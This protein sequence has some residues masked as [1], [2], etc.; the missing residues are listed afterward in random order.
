MQERLEITLAI[1][2]GA[3]GLL[4]I[5]WAL[6]RRKI[7]PFFRTILRAGIIGAIVST[8]LWA[9]LAWGIPTA[10]LFFALIGAIM[11][12]ISGTLIAL[13]KHNVAS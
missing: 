12:A 13:A 6:Y 7:P 8:I 5:S 4:L 3:I 9:F 11:G 1:V 2:F 10:W